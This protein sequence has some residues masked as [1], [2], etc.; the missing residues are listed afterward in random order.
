MT[1][2]EF[3]A[4]PDFVSMGNKLLREIIAENPDFVYNNGIGGG[5]YYWRGVGD[6]QQPSPNP[7]NGCLFGQMFQ[8][9]GVSR[10]HL[11]QKDYGS[12]LGFDVTLSVEVPDYWIKMQDEQDQ[13]ASW[14][15]LLKHLPKDK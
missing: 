13:G 11:K 4:N 15:S 9:A 5:C 8:K 10:E 1:L 6:Y 12:L 3:F 7:C 2:K 14:G